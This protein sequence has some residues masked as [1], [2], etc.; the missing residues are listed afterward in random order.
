MKHKIPSIASILMT[1]ALCAI[2]QNGFAQCNFIVAPSTTDPGC[3][4]TSGVCSATTC[5][6][7]GHCAIYTLT[8][9]DCDTCC[10]AKIKIFGVPPGV[11]WTACAS[12]P[13]S[14]KT[15]CS[16][17]AVEL[18]GGNICA[19]ESVVIKLCSSVSTTFAVAGLTT[20]CPQMCDATLTTP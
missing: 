14:S 16:N 5:S 12:S 15:V 9:P 11:C 7:G 6:D 13:W 8:V 2:A 10:V 18:T 17:G 20:L 4:L 1:L 3:T 19:G